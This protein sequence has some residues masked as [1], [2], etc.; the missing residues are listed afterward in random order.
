MT[1]KKPVLEACVETLDEGIE[2]CRLGAHQ[3]EVCSRLDLDG[4]TP[5]ADFVSQLSASVK[6][7]LKIMIRP[8][9]GVFYYTSEEIEGM[10]ADVINF[11]AMRIDGFVTGALVKS[12]D[13]Q[14][15]VDVNAMIRLCKAAFP[16]PVTMHKAIDECTDLIREV[17][18]L[19]Q[20]SNLHF[21]LTSGGKATALEGASA[22]VDMQKA[23]SPSIDVIA[24]G[25][26]TPDNLPQL[27]ELTG[28]QYFH[29]RRIV[30]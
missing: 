24:A 1:Q 20:I 29:G 19:R 5:G 16:F 18:V 2:A 10:M 23:A 4:L 28:L 15:R 30:G 6:V 12:E 21:I 22:L 17:Q 11:K 27:K 9:E 25:R 14:V 8:R 3:L 13:N 26:I 7:P